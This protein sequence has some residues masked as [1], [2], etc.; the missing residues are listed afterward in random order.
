MANWVLCCKATLFAAIVTY[1]SV[2][3][4]KT[5]WGQMR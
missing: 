3:S 5:K 1:H 2:H 4:I